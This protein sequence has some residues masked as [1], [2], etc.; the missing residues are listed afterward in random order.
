MAEE[1]TVESFG[2]SDCLGN[3]TGY[4]LVNPDGSTFG[5]SDRRYVADLYDPDKSHAKM[6][7]MAEDDANQINYLRAV[8]W[9]AREPGAMERWYKKPSADK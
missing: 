7:Q 4:E 8:N 9:A 6:R 5:D 3:P 2:P 1:L